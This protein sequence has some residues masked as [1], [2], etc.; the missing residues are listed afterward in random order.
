VHSVLR[1]RP[2]SPVRC[3]PPFGRRTSGS[4]DSTVSRLETRL[5]D[6][7]NFL[8]DDDGLLKIGQ[9]LEITSVVFIQNCGV[10]SDPGRG[11]GAEEAPSEKNV[12][13]F[14]SRRFDWQLGG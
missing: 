12:R 11:Q 6:Q 10:V 3:S 5:F 4:R 14:H 13:K 1:G 8:V 2:S 9:G 7:G